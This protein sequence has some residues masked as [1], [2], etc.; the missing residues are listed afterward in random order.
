MRRTRR[1]YAAHRARW[2]SH[3]RSDT[4]RPTGRVSRQLRPR[5]RAP[6]GICPRLRRGIRA[7]GFR[8]AESCSRTRK[9]HRV[10]VVS[11]Q[12]RPRQ[13]APSG[14][15]PRL[16]RGI[17][18]AGNRYCG[19]L[20]AKRKTHR[21][22]L[23]SVQLTRSTSAEATAG[24]ESLHPSAL[25]ARCTR[26]SSP[27][28][29]RRQGSMRA[30]SSQIAIIWISTQFGLD[31]RIALGKSTQKCTEA[32]WPSSGLPTDLRRSDCLSECHRPRA[33]RP[34]CTRDTRAPG[35]RGQ[36]VPDGERRS[37]RFF[38]Y[39]PHILA[40]SLVCSR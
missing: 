33:L 1:G 15:C 29:R 37:L 30:N 2:V 27:A 40:S 11:R 4:R 21:V 20:L 6:S 8:L 12:L 32:Q 22:G 3:P 9:M 16:R 14:I 38:L 5:Q 28:F 31:V 17:R 24:R 34:R 10:G 19:F 36:A 35:K 25:R 26:K 18:A 7:A 39:K 23:A 13:R